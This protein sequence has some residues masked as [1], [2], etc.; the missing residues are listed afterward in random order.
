MTEG[1]DA[2]EAI[3]SSGY[4]SGQLKMLFQ[5]LMEGGKKDDIWLDASG[6]IC[7]FSR[8]TNSVYPIMRTIEAAINEAVQIAIALKMPKEAFKPVGDAINNIQFN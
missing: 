6:Q 5:I 1:Y 3:V 4:A 8:E 2:F 7:I